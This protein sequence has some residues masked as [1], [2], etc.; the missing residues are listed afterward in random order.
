ML[1]HADYVITA[2]VFPYEHEDPWAVSVKFKHR[3]TGKLNETMF[4][5][6]EDY[7]KVSAQCAGQLKTREPVS[8]SHAPKPK[9]SV[10][11][12]APVLVK[13]KKRA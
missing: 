6:R 7:M 10:A 1:N 2:I 4:N 5:G 13:G 12:A 11:A 9:K 8:A 3:R